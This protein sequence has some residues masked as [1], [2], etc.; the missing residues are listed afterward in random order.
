MK[1]FRSLQIWKKA[2]TLT[3]DIYR[4][5]KKF[6]KDEIFGLVSQIRRSSASISTNI[7][8]GCG[9]DGDAELGRFLQI[10]RGSASEVENHLLLARDLDY[11]E[12]K[13]FDDLS[14]RV[15][16]LKRMLTGFIFKLRAD[17]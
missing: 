11:L 10:A 17:R 9:R 4:A 5:T 13:V 12:E 6:P 3:L 2:H 15:V 8:E 16:E 7:A 14:S 1:D